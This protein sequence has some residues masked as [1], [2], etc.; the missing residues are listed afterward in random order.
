M[1]NSAQCLAGSRDVQRL[2]PQ[3]LTR[4]L[5]AVWRRDRHG[6]EQP[7]HHQSGLRPALQRSGACRCDSGGWQHQSQPVFWRAAAH[8]HR[9]PRDGRTRWGARLSFRCRTGH[10]WLSCARRRTISQATV[11]S[12]P[13]A[14]RGSTMPA[15]SGTIRCW[16]ST[17]KPLL[18]RRPQGTGKQSGRTVAGSAADA[19][20]SGLRRSCTFRPAT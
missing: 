2:V 17:P 10:G 19:Q 13:R 4:S 6:G 3:P 11:P 12:R 18:H 5:R 1:A 14:F 16:C 8:A 20:P 7:D 9:N 15:M